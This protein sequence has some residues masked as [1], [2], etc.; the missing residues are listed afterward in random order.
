VT[1]SALRSS[2][3]RR[4]RVRTPIPLP[5]PIPILHAVTS[6]EIASR[7]DFVQR[8]S[9]VMHAVGPR[10]AV[11]LRIHRLSAAEIHALA[12]ALVRVQTET[13]CWLVINDR[14]DVA[15]A[16]GARAIQLTS[17]SMAISDARTIAPRVPVG[18][19]VHRP[20]EA[21]A[22]EQEG[23]SWAVAGHVYNTGSPPSEAARGADFIKA[24]SDSTL[25]PVIA[26]GG[27][28]PEHVGPLRRAGAWGVA[29][30]RGIWA[31]SDSGAAATDYLSH[32][33]A[34]GGA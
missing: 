4:E 18:A 17:R 24:V 7:P 33:D 13:D 27:I 15:I 6:D 1:I 26:I 3:V 14:V 9:D 20:E 12:T 30:I 23:A 22:A 25:I 29:V 31:A 2:S 19:S 11:H 16:T 5:S 8:A 10:G 32:Y 34:D 21:V 28:R